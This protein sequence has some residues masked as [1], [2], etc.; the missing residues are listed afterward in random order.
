MVH[1]LLVSISFLLNEH[2]TPEAG[3][4]LIRILALGPAPEAASIEQQD[5]GWQNSFGTGNA[6]DTTTAGPEVI[7]T[8]TPTKWGNGE[9]LHLFSSDPFLHV[10]I[11]S[12]RLSHQS[13]HEHLDSRE[14]PGRCSSV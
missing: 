4:V 7:W 5:L 2:G 6:D 3:L 12:R 1:L 13:P 11:L 10:L 14:K 9:A 8:K